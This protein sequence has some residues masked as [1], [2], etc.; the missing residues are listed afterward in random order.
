MWVNITTSNNYPLV[1]ANRHVSCIK[2]IVK[3]LIWFAWM[4]AENAYWEDLGQKN[5]LFMESLQESNIQN[6]IGGLNFFNE[7]INTNLL[8]AASVINKKVPVSALSP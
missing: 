8:K 1:I 5:L 3:F 6:W 7:M 4:V 2:D